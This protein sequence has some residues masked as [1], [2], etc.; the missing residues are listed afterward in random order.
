MIEEAWYQS[1]KNLS[2]EDGREA[3]SAIMQT[4]IFGD[5]EP[6]HILEKHDEIISKKLLSSSG[7]ESWISKAP[8]FDDTIDY[9]MPSREF[10]R[11]LERERPKR[12]R[13]LDPHTEEIL[14]IQN[15][16]A[17]EWKIKNGSV[18]FIRPEPIRTR[19]YLKKK[20]DFKAYEGGK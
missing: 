1:L 4:T 19:T 14:L 9:E 13:A 20:R 16:A 11:F 15:P 7:M 12:Y 3:F 5:V 18:A 8:T 2:D 17:W 6:A 10:C